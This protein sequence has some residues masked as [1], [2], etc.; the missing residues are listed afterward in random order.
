MTSY[1]EFE[2][3]IV[4]SNTIHRSCFA[5]YDFTSSDF[6]DKTIDD[7]FSFYK[8]NDEDYW[9]YMCDVILEF[10]EQMKN[11]YDEY[12]GYDMAHYIN[13][14]YNNLYHQRQC[15]LYELF[16][17]TYITV[18][19][20]KLAEYIEIHRKPV[21]YY[22]LDI[23][24]LEEENVDLHDNVIQTFQNAFNEKTIKTFCIKCGQFG[25]E[26]HSTVTTFAKLR[27]KSG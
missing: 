25:H 23:F 16:H 21:E 3:K 19:A 27:G 6:H 17:E 26:C 7:L 10:I 5:R 8:D 2:D 12:N 9:D 13:D 14:C 4:L 24:E 22:S 18:Y 11:Y 20:R 15:E 1:L